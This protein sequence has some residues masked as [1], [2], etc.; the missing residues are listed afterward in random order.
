MSKNFVCLWYNINYWQNFWNALLR[1]LILHLQEKSSIFLTINQEGLCNILLKHIEFLASPAVLY[2]R[3]SKSYILATFA[4]RTFAIFSIKWFSNLKEL[5][6]INLSILHYFFIQEP[7]NFVWGCL[8][9]IFF[10]IFFHFWGW[11]VLNLFV[12]SPTQLCNATK[13]C[14]TVYNKN[15][16]FHFFHSFSFKQR[17]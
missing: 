7:V 14:Q 6:Q 9:F 13:N 15:T 17:T 12:I 8:F 10:L 16:L 1:L 2:K 3:I 11:N 4:K 5:N